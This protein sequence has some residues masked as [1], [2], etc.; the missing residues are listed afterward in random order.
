MNDGISFKINHLN[1]IINDAHKK[2][3][4]YSKYGLVNPRESPNGNLIYHLYNDG[5]ITY[6]KGGWAYLQ[7]SEF[8]CYPSIYELKKFNFK[9]LNYNNSGKTYVILSKIECIQY[10]K[11]MEDLLKIQNLP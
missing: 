4:E 3:Y 11:Q 5:E 9:F 7:R 1:N 2:H 8:T 6:Q 10:R